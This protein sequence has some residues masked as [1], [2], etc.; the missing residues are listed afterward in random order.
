M[1]LCIIGAGVMGSASA[2]YSCLRTPGARVIVL[3][4]YPLLHKLGS[5]HGESRITRRTYPSVLYTTMMRRAFELWAD[6]ER[7]AGVSVYR[8]TGG[9]D[10]LPKAAPVFNA[11][12]DACNH[13]KAPIDILSASQLREQYG[14]HFSDAHVGVYQADTGVLRATATVAMFQALARAHGAVFRDRCKAIACEDERSSDGVR[15]RVT[16]E[17]GTVVVASRVIVACGPWAQPFLASVFSLHLPLQV[18]QCT[19]M[20]FRAM[21]GQAHALRQL[22]ALPVLIDYGDSAAWTSAT[23]PAATSSDD[24]P[25]IYSC[26]QGDFPDLIK[27]AVHQGLPTTADARTFVP[28]A[29][30]TVAP[31]QR[32]LRAHVP[33]LDPNPVI[34]ET[35][36]YTMTPEEDFVIDTV[37]GRPH[38]VVACGFSGHGFKFACLIG[39]VCA[40]LSSTGE[41]RSVDLEPFRIDRPALRPPAA[42][43]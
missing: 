18:W 28:H 15:V 34:S 23:E 35:C 36:L 42:R 24:N 2:Y 43:M 38:I 6:A 14:I 4:Q 16:C 25:T 32:W 7:A 39:D 33:F 31:V 22:H 30:S 29:E 10:V 37:P 11:L 40:E 9:I 26:P 13:V 17:D 41:C 8:R 27:F 12:V 5:S 20:Y 1:D 3:E 19:V 21:E